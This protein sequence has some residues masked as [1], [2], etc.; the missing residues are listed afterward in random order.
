MNLHLWLVMTTVENRK[1]AE[2][3]AAEL[4][5]RRLAACVSIG[6]TLTSVYPWQGQIETAEETPLMIK[7][8]PQRLDALKSALEK[9]HP[10]DVPEMLVLPVNDGLPAYFAWAHEWTNHEN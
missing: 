5:E 6:A 3:L 8:S 7:T 9:L 1:Q 10:Y 2:R 4:V